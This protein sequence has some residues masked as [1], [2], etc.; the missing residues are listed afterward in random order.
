MGAI[1]GAGHA[2]SYVMTVSSPTRVLIRAKKRGRS[3]LD[4][5]LEL[6]DQTGGLIASN[7]DSGGSTNSSIERDL[8]PGQYRITVRGYNNTLGAYLIS[9]VA[10]SDSQTS[11]SH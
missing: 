5:Y 4:T 11:V 8:Q 1:T 9:V 3:L 6:F 10:L 2:D 7:D